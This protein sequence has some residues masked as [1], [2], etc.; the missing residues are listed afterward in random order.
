M[1]KKYYEICCRFRE[2]FADKENVKITLTVP[3]SAFYKFSLN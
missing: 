2:R 3:D 1:S